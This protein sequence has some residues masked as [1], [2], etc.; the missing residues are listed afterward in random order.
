MNIFHR[1]LQYYTSRWRLDLLHRLPLVF[2]FAAERAEEA[3]PGVWQEG[4]PPVP[5]HL[6]WPRRGVSAWRSARPRAL[7]CPQSQR[8]SHQET[9]NQQQQPHVRRSRRPTHQRTHPHYPT[10]T[11]WLHHQAEASWP[12][13]AERL[14]DR[15]GKSTEEST[16][17]A[18]VE[19]NGK[20]W[21]K[22]RCRARR[23]SGRIPVLPS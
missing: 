6:Q 10:T 8:L 12:G 17:G 4:L 19:S 9:L 5:Q 3:H 13:R 22:R 2:V 14:D 11:N 20:N 1:N 16:D 21:T 7:R 18:A 23:L 15:G